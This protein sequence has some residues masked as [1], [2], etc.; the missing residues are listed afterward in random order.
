MVGGPLELDAGTEPLPRSTQQIKQD[1][2]KDPPAV[3][4][5]PLAR[6][7]LVGG[8]SRLKP[9]RESLRQTQTGSLLPNV[10]DG[11]VKS[12]VEIRV[13]EGRSPWLSEGSCARCV[14]SCK[15]LRRVRNIRYAP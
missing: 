6:Q 13:V 7:D 14:A 15:R 3:A 9:K 4:I 8:L 1:S 2:T 5:A 11:E 10:V 12:Q